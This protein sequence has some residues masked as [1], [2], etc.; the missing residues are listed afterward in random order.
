MANFNLQQRI[1]YTKGLKELLIRVCSDYQIGKHISHKIILMGY[2]DCNL[3]LKTDKN[4]Y[5]VKL[6]A[7]FRDDAECQRYVE[8]IQKALN[9]GVKHPFLHKFNNDPLYQIKIE[10]V[11]IRLAV[12]DFTDGKS[13][14]ELKTK[15][16]NDEIKFIVKQAALINQIE[17][18]QSFVY[19]SWAISNF[20]KEYKEKG[21]YLLPPDDKLIASLAVQFKNL[22]IDRLPHCFVHG[23][24]TRTNTMKDKNGNLFIIDF[25]CAN[26]YP[27]IQELAVLLCDLFFDPQNP[28]SFPKMYDFV[29]AEY[30]KYIKLTKEEKETLP[31]YVKFAHAMH[32]LRANYERIVE[33]NETE[34]N[35]YFLSIGRIGL[36]FTE[37][38]WE[39]NQ[40]NKSS[41][42]WN[43]K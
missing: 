35:N 31:L 28:N 10:D 25:A 2:E 38:L 6:F 32:L 26:Y 23:D 37:K 42:I 24:I 8:I 19:D 3:I 14:Y 17:L 40:K 4:N 39:N 41:F 15:L 20:E 9:A 22:Q 43:Q 36:N 34:E 29:V 18:K 5:F 12:M 30:E 21:K 27:R 13:I 7:L 16:N 1:G 11:K 33:K